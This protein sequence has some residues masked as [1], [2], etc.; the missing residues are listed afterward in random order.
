MAKK[1]NFHY[2]KMLSQGLI[3][4]S[5][6]QNKSMSVHTVSCSNSA[7]A[8]DVSLSAG[9]QCFLFT[10]FNCL[11]CTETLITES[12]IDVLRFNLRF[13][14]NCC[15]GP[16]DC[17]IFENFSSILQS[18]CIL[19]LRFFILAFFSLLTRFIAQAV[20]NNVYLMV[21]TMANSPSKAAIWAGR[22]N[23]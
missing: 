11:F 19:L 8:R 2:V 4:H 16:F 10:F 1:P 12:F 20:W 17:Y 15:P 5:I 3:W 18:N 21:M 7:H 13:L 23:D 6:N 9:H 14:T 22:H